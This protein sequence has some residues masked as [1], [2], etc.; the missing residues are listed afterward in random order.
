MIRA[1]TFDLWDTMVRDDSDEARR[2]AKGLR[3]KR[4]ERRHLVWQALYGVEAIDFDRVALAYDVTD[5]AFSQVWHNQHITWTIQDRLRVLLKG[6]GRKLPDAAFD[7][8]A[9]AHEEMEIEMP[10]DPVEGIA[11]ALAE[12][13]TRYQLAVVSDTIVSPGRCLRRLLEIHG[14]KECF[15][16]FAFSDEVGHSKPNRA[17]FDSAARQL[18]VDLAQM[19]HVGDRDSN[20]VKGPQALGMKAI[21]F[22]MVIDRGKEASSADAICEDA[23]DLPAIVDR[24]AAA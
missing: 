11:E 9:R 13:A 6:L 14:L 5:A 20:D 2:A 22:T 24:L 23:R 1:V 19:V 21:L 12:L 8:V 3:S 18:G 10:P 15:S 17:M 4:E 7:E 16:G